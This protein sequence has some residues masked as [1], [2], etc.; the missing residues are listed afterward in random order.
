M[1]FAN[2]RCVAWTALSQI[3]RDTVSLACADNLP[4]E[5]PSVKNMDGVVD[6]QAVLQETGRIQSMT[7]TYHNED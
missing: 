1:T 7:K 2:G 3:E 5:E 6:L 4:H